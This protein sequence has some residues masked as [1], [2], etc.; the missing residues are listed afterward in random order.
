VTDRATD[1]VGDRAWDEL[2]RVTGM[3]HYAQ[4]VQGGPPQPSRASIPADPARDTDLVIG[5]AL[6]ERTRLRE[7]L[8]EL[9]A[10]WAPVAAALAAPDGSTESLRDAVAAFGAKLGAA[11]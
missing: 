10:A 6:G 11:S 3:E 5:A 2:M 8:A 1:V 4:R 7:E 9:R